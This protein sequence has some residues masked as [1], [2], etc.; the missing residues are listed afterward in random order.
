MGG[1]GT[2]SGGGGRRGTHLYLR[3]GDGD[4]PGL[5]TELYALAQVRSEAL[6]LLGPLAAVLPGAAVGDWGGGRVVRGHLSAQAQR[7][8]R[9]AETAS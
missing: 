4:V 3:H 7:K 8:P 2:D 6:W 9:S 5:Y 1:A